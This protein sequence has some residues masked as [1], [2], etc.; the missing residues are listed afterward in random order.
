MYYVELD[1]K[2]LE[3]PSHYYFHLRPHSPLYQNL[4][5]IR[6]KIYQNFKE[7][8][9]H[10]PNNT[11]INP[12]RIEISKKNNIQDYNQIIQNL[13]SVATES[14]EME[15]IFQK[16]CLM[17]QLHQVKIHIMT[18]QQVVPYLSS[19]RQVLQNPQL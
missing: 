11:A 2:I 9:G 15:L 8:I 4:Q 14:E 5:I 10:H 17:I 1:N 6:Q 18:F 19:I 13:E 7:K 16:H 12:F 3:T